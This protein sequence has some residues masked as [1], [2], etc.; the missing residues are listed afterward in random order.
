[1]LSDIPNIQSTIGAIKLNFEIN[2]ATLIT[3]HLPLID[4]DSSGEQFICVNIMPDSIIGFFLK[5]Q[6]HE[7]PN[8]KFS[9]PQMVEI[10]FTNL[11]LERLIDIEVWV[12]LIF[13]KLTKF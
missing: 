3:T 6:I 11:S 1:L 8:R 2:N 13:N 10:R 12:N 5:T 4:V 9:F 7:T